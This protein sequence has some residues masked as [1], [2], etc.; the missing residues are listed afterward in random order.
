MIDIYKNAI[1]SSWN[2]KFHVQK[3][4]IINSTIALKNM[5]VIKSSMSLIFGGMM[6]MFAR[7]ILL[8]M[9]ML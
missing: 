6:L 8:S 4:T 3:N 2:K 7:V 5:I 1:P 9:A